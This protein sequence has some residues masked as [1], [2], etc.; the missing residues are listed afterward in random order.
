MYENVSSK[1]TISGIIVF[2][3]YFITWLRPT[4][5]WIAHT[6]FPQLDSSRRYD[7]WELSSHERFRVRPCG[8]GSAK[9]C[10]IPRRNCGWRTG[11]CKI[12]KYL[13]HLLKR[14]GTLH[15]K[16][17]CTTWLVA[18]YDLPRGLALSNDIAPQ[19]TN[20][21]FYHLSSSRLSIFLV[22]YNMWSHSLLL[23]KPIFDYLFS[24]H[25]RVTAHTVTA[26]DVT[27][28]G[29]TYDKTV[30]L[31]KFSAEVMA[32]ERRMGWRV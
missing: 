18:L 25:A 11:Q 4:L 1:F 22:H 16:M 32:R 2:Q 3:Q 14:T 26:K 8:H 6:Q 9:L 12:C 7:S 20:F 19:Y 29:P 21:N 17:N 24:Q 27:P 15:L 10:S 5:S 23:I 13:H 30:F 31:V 28:G